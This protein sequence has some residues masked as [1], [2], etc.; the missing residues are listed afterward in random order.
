MAG[1][2]YT[3]L[4][5]SLRYLMFSVFTVTPGQLGEDRD[6][7][8]ADLEEFLARYDGPTWWS[9]VSTTSRVCAPRPTS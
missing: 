2:D 6:A 8:A 1:L 3:K 4:N 7:V 9:G 5:S